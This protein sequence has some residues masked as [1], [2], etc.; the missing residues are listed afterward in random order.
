[1]SRLNLIEQTFVLYN[2]QNQLI[3]KCLSC[4]EQDLLIIII[5][6]LIICFLFLKYTLALFMSILF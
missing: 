3:I 1:M 2:K 5:N 4:D 6:F